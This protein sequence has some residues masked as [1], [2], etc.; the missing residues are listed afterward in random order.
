MLG[1]QAQVPNQYLTESKL[2]NGRS[3]RKPLIVVLLLAL[4]GIGGWWVYQNSTAGQAQS[5]PGQMAN[6]SG[7]AVTG[8]LP[9]LGTN[10][11]ESTAAAQA[12]SAGTTAGTGSASA[13]Q[14]AVQAGTSGDQAADQGLNLASLAGVAEVAGTPVWND[15]GTLLATLESGSL[16]TV[17]ARTR[18]DTWLAVATDAGSGWAQAS[19]VIAYGLH[20]LATVALPEAVASASVAGRLYSRRWRLPPVQ[21]LPIYRWRTWFPRHHQLRRLPVVRSLHRPR[22]FS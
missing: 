18:D 4:V 6:V 3:W 12:S 9:G 17:K 2:A 5:A 1:T 22:L 8:Q 13:G 20:N 15:D 16:L 10:I 14:P 19:T 7:S 21:P 11:S